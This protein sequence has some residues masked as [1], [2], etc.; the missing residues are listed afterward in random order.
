M[1]K[2]KTEFINVDRA[3]KEYV[4]R[5]KQM[6]EFNKKDAKKDGLQSIFIDPL[7]LN[8]NYWGKVRT[9]SPYYKGV[10][11]RTLRR[12]SEKAWI[13]NLC[14][15]NIIKKVR[16][17]LKPIQENNNRGFSIKKKRTIDNNSQKMTT[18]EKKV[19]R[20]LEEFFLNTGDVEDLNRTDD[21]DKYVSKLLRDLCQLDQIACEIEK[22]KGGEVCAFWAVDPATIEIALSQSIKETGIKFVQVI[23]HIPYAFYEEGE[24]LFDCMNPRTDIERS[25]YGYS[26]VE[27]AID[28]ITSSINTFIYNA[29]FFTENKIPR[30]FL[31]LNGDADQEEV[32][33]MEDYIVNIMSGSPSSLWRVPIV[34]SGKNEGGEGSRHLE[35]V[36]LQGTNKEMEF[37][38]WFDLQLSGIVGLFGFS[39]EDLGLHS[40]KSA[41]LI[42]NDVSPK[43]ESS[44]SLVLGDM[45]SFLQKHFNMILKY[46]NP[47]YEF[48]FVGYERD[49]P[50]VILDMDK[51]EVSSYK[52]LNEKREEKGYKALD[53][54]EI[55]NPANLPMNPQV[56]Q[57]WQGVQ[58]GGNEEEMGDI[59]GEG[60]MQDMGMQGSDEDVDN[61]EVEANDDGEEALLDNSEGEDSKDLENGNKKRVTWDMLSKSLKFRV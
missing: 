46:K 59:D 45:L 1:N 17:F 21:L 12:V 13:L 2:I 33:K 23:N 43:I 58:Q 52:T 16:P 31:L 60:M 48:E 29:G 27:Q 6:L 15:S 37:Q 55:K 53:F 25:G 20:E 40:Q 32:D 7:M 36:N 34:P 38:A 8:T 11:Y 19:A 56:I 3:I 39:M 9:I 50:K 30:G 26:V 57:A 51:E 47:E 5:Q 22:T 42:G 28:L 14:I 18:K 10:S 61:A 49:D 54:T 41:P 4:L 35:W 44:K 24:L